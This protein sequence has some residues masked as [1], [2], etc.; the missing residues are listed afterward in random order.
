MI[1][2]GD[3]CPSDIGV[4][5]ASSFIWQKKSENQ[6]NSPLIIITTPRGC[7]WGPNVTAN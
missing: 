7:H 2:N 4:R 6:T 5:A 1:I 3:T